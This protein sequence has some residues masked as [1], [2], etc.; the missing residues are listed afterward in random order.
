MTITWRELNSKD[1]AQVAKLTER[2]QHVD[3]PPYRTS[4]AEIEADFAADQRWRAFGAFA[5]ATLVAFGHA[6]F[7]PSQ[8][9][10]VLCIGGVDPDYRRQKLGGRIVDLQLQAGKELLGGNEGDVV[11]HVD[12]GM[13]EL[14][15]VLASRGF[16]WT[17][18]YYELRAS[19]DSFPALQADPFISIVPWSA[20][21][22]DELRLAVNDVTGQKWGSSPLSEQEWEEGRPHFSEQHS[23]I[24]LD[25]S[26]DRA[27]IAGLV[28]CSLYKQDWQALGLKECDVDIFA[29]AEPWRQTNVGGRLLTAVMQQCAEDGLDAIGAGISSENDS[30]AL[31]LYHSLGFRTVARTRAYT[32]HLSD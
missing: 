29:V 12:E 20:D 8:P 11:M 21:L 24:A 28:M 31:D 7:R 22:D 32:V 2:I 30:G 9:P 1:S 10:R 25:K 4:R 19:L 5:G 17:K 14:V 15:D 23:F 3:N 16:T 18:T 26:T 6:L 27:Q 13:A